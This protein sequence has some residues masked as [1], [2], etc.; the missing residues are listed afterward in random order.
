MLTTDVLPMHPKCLKKECL[1]QH[2]PS[3][4][5]SVHTCIRHSMSM[6]RRKVWWMFAVLSKLSCLRSKFARPIRLALH[7][8]PAN[9]PSAVRRFALHQHSLTTRKLLE[10]S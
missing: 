6:L 2:L 4:A 8:S 9:G 5:I 10:T 7:V 1:F 3:I